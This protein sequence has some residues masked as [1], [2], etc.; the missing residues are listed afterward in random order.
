MSQ[1]N[2]KKATRKLSVFNG[3]RVPFIEKGLLFLS[4]F[5]SIIRAFSGEKLV[6]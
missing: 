2:W 6:V 3:F 4:C 5:L 1:A